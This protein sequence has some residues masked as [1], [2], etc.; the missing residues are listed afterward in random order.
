MHS[1]AVTAVAGCHLGNEQECQ[2]PDARTFSIRFKSVDAI[3]VRMT[4]A[5]DG[6]PATLARWAPAY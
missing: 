6:W 2:P 4:P 3:I 5:V 1:R